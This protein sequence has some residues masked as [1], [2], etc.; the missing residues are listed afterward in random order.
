MF[1]VPRTFDSLVLI[2]FSKYL[3]RLSLRC[4]RKS[5]ALG[6]AHFNIYNS[7]FVMSPP[8]VRSIF[9]INDFKNGPFTSYSLK[10]AFIL[11]GVIK[12]WCIKMKFPLATVLGSVVYMQEEC[13]KLHLTVLGRH[14]VWG[15][16]H[17]LA[18]QQLIQQTI[19]CN[20]TGDIKFEV[21]SNLLLY[22]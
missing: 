20:W 16:G 2:Q 19:R 7:Q 8:S 11:A 15:E 6:S 21:L 10:T 22:T 4:S 5:F 13:Q 14:V 18:P 12:L 9:G 1:Q 17:T 3:K